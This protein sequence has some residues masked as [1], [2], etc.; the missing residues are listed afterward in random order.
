MSQ[1][2]PADLSISLCHNK[3]VRVK[4]RSVLD[5]ERSLI[6]INSAQ[7]YLSFDLRLDLT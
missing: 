6:V 2:S 7:I 4:C 5:C 1:A 3:E